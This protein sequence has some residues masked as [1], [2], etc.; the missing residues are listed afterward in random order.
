MNELEDLVNQITAELVERDHCVYAYGANKKLP[1]IEVDF[2]NNF[3][4]DLYFLPNAINFILYAD[5]LN[6]FQGGVENVWLLEYADPEFPDDLYR[7]IKE[8]EEDR[9]DG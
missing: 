5:C 8:I 7:K 4:A 1:H 9:Y 2:P 3:N 6:E